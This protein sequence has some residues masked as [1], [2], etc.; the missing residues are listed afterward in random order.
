MYP[1]LSYLLHD[2][3]GTPPDNFFS[4]IKTFGVLLLLAFLS[5]AALLRSELKRREHIGQLQGVE[6]VGIKGGRVTW[7]DCAF[8]AALGFALGFKIPHLL[9]GFRQF[10]RDPSAALF[11][12]E[13]NW[14]TGVLGALVL[15]GYYA[16]QLRR[17]G[18]AVPTKRTI[19]PSDR[20]GP[21]T[22]CAAVGGIL[23]AKF[24]AIIENLEAFFAAPLATLLSG[25]GL[26]IYGG[27]IGGAVAVFLYL[28]K[29]GIP[30][31]P[32]TDAVA[33]GLIVAYGVGRI[34]CQLS[35]DGDWGIPSPTVPDWWFLPD[36]VF[37]FDFPH[38]VAERGVLMADCTFEYCHRLPEPVYCTS[39]YETVAAF[40]IG[41]LLWALRKPLTP[42]P[43]ALF[44][45]YLVLNGIERFLIEFIRVNDRYPV[46]GI[47]LSQAQIVAIG[48]FVAGLALGAF[49]W[50][51]GERSHPA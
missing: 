31:L 33:P 14:L 48:F 6:A 45:I 2:L 36:W 42:R 35:G 39:I 47:E 16:Y 38:N 21:I 12:A 27:L 51:R 41:G 37:S 30:A 46:L 13:G 3:L 26:A 11:S 44:S 1:D 5:A 50:W 19:Y 7:L 29:Y 4:L 25:N 9:G 8:N 49:A 22:L 17:Q 23:G 32:V 34:G 40:A 43:G 15:G 24:F 10:Q 28:R 20:I 18:E